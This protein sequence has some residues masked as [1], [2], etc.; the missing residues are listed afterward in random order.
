MRWA[1]REE[2]SIRRLKLVVAVSPHGLIIIV[3]TQP[4][5][6]GAAHFPGTRDYTY[7]R[8]AERKSRQRD[9]AQR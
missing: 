3:V 5:Y 4:N 9:G 6:D 7:E 1:K 8:R 2:A